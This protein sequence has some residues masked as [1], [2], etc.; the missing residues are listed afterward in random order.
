MLWQKSYTPS[1]TTIPAQEILSKCKAIGKHNVVT[2]SEYLTAS[3]SF[4]VEVNRLFKKELKKW[5]L[6]YGNAYDCANFSITY[7]DIANKLYAQNPVPYCEGIAVG[8][9]L[10][11]SGVSKAH[12]VNF[13]VNED[14]E[15]IVIEPQLIDAW[16]DGKVELSPIDWEWVTGVIV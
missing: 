11:R 2:D 10:Y 6:K 7:I 4:L 3:D 1:K 16:N 12:M 5:G 9:L 14:Y 15:L 13:A 8:C